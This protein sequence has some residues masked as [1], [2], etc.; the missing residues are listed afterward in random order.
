M[1]LVEQHC[2]VRQ[3]Q[4]GVDAAGQRG[5]RADILLAQARWEEAVE[6]YSESYR[7]DLTSNDRLWGLIGRAR[8]Y[9]RLG[10]KD[11]ARRDYFVARLEQTSLAWIYREAGQW[12]LHG[13]FA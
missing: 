13:F 6:A 2:A 11:E 8:A 3:N 10:R 1:R 12:Y 9:L 7:A 4:R 5:F